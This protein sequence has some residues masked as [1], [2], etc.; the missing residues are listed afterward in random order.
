MRPERAEKVTKREVTG[1]VH[2]AQEQ[3]RRTPEGQRRAR[4]V[5]LE[6]T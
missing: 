1:A 3:A 5:D 6:D 4:V 2:G